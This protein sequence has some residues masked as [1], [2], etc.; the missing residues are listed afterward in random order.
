MARIFNL[1]QESGLLVQR[2]VTVS[3][4]GILGIQDGDTEVTIN[5]EKIIIGGD[6]ILSINGV[7]FELTDESLL[8]I[9]KV[10]E[11]SKANDP[12]EIIVLRGGKIVTLGRRK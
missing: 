3:P 11:Q 5:G 2:V 4:F 6:I 9:S 7:K 8:N 12:I 10:I 1:P